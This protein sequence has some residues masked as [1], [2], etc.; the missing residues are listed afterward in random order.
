MKKYIALFAC[1]FMVACSA[2]VTDGSKNTNTTEADV[3]HVIL[4]GALTEIVYRLGADENIVGLDVT[5]TYPEAAVDLPKVGYPRQISAEGLLSLQPSHLITIDDAGPKS[6]LDQIKATG[7][8]IITIE[9]PKTLDGVYAAISKLGD[10]T[11]TEDDARALVAAMKVKQETLAAR[12]KNG[13]KPKAILVLTHGKGPPMVAGLGT[14]GDEILALSGVMNAASMIDGYK[15]LT[16]ESAAQLAPDYIILSAQGMNEGTA[17][18]GL[19]EAPGIAETPAGE[20]KKILVMDPLLL[21][22]F[23][24]RTLDAAEMIINY[25]Q[26]NGN[27]QSEN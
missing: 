27:D 10:I 24:P 5:S 7:V 23:G 17:K 21:L 25:T 26:P 19:L 9:K 8:E 14:A 13:N 22:G 11:K 4:G 12:T 6:A 2:D 16:P 15:P 1:V 18:S 3:R 20:N